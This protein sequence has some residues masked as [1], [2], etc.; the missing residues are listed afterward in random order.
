LIFMDMV[1]PRVDGISATVSIRKN[2]LNKD[3]CIIFVT[4]DVSDTSY[5][6]CMNSGGT[7]H[8]TK[9]VSRIVLRSTLFKY[10]LP[11]EIECLRRNNINDN[12]MCK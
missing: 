6:K 9:P 2:G 1:M 5:D 12:M 7:D 4:A 10:L 3:V 11:P 8:L